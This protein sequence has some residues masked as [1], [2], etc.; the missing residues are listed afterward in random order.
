MTRGQLSLEEHGAI[1]A[2]LRLV[3]FRLS[4]LLRD[5]RERRVPVKCLNAASKAVGKV[6]QLR[7]AL[8]DLADEPGFEIYSG[9]RS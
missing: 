4:R 9:G 3:Q 1:A 6:E 7:L 8:Q 2:E 5:L